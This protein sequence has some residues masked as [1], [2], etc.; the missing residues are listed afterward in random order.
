MKTHF[1][2]VSEYTAKEVIDEYDVY[3]CDKGHKW[4]ETLETKYNIPQPL[5]FSVPGGD[6]VCP[7]CLGELL[8]KLGKVSIR[9]VKKGNE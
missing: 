8:S 2:S 7:F 3:A 5:Y 4:E 9:T 1:E 6:R